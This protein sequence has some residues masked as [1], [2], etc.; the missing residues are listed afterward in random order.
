MSLRTS[1]SHLKAKLG[2]YM[3]SV[4]EGKDVVVTDRGQP[5]ARLVPYRQPSAGDELR[6]SHPRDPS[7]PALGRL[8][9]RAI[10]YKGKD[11]TTL[12]GEDRRRR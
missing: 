5:V 11:T 3:K 9:V 12:L 7:A 2:Q 10:R 8:E 6:A 4:R 1:A